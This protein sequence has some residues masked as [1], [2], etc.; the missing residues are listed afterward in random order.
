MTGTNPNANSRTSLV[1]TKRTLANVI[2]KQHCITA[3]SA[4]FADVARL[5]PREVRG[6][7]VDDFT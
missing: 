4:A 6:V 1:P 7:M 3:Q 5:G 2:I